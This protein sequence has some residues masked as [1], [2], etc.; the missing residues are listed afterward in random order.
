MLK[1]MRRMKMVEE[2]DITLASSHKHIKNTH[3]YLQNDTHGTSA[4]RWQNLHLRKGQDTLHV[5]G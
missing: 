4:E 1:C 2:S 3:I 5:P